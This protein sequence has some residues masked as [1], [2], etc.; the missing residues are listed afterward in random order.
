MT[1]QIGS[2]RLFQQPDRFQR[3]AL[4]ISFTKDFA[5][6]TEAEKPLL[7]LNIRLAGKEENREKIVFLKKLPCIL[8]GRPRNE[9]QPA[10]GDRPPRGRGPVP[11]AGIEGRPRFLLTRSREDRRLVRSSPAGFPLGRSDSLTQKVCL[12]YFGLLCKKTRK[13][14]I[15]MLGTGPVRMEV[16]IAPIS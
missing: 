7:L 3:T 1:S 11:F 14:K 2:F 8:G 6:S 13:G 15:R 16:R 4:F 10:E 5:F 12:F 9:I